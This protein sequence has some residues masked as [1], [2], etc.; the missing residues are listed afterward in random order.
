MNLCEKCKF[1]K[2]CEKK[3][4]FKRLREEI[5]RTYSEYGYVD[6]QV[7]IKCFKYKKKGSD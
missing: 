6:T 5:M 4:A 2:E 3:F 7:S 1:N